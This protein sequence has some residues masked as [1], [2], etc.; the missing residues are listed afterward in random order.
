M[1]KVFDDWSPVTYLILMPS[2][3]FKD[4]IVWQK[5]L[6]LMP[7]L[8]EIAKQLPTFERY[9][10]AGQ[11]RRAAVSIPSNIAEGSRRGSPAAFRQFCTIAQG[12]AAEIETQLLAVEKLYQTVDV[13]DPLVQVLQ[14][15]K[16][17]TALINSLR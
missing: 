9:G 10:L 5:S 4:L 2:V 7:V 3:S 1:I 11:L 16:M 8:Y 15:Q 14:I 12:S 13:K 6:D 17:L